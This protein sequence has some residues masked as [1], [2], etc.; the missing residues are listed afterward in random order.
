MG[1]GGATQAPDTQQYCGHLAGGGG[2]FLP[3]FML[4]RLPKGFPQSGLSR[5]YMGPAS[6][7]AG[8]EAK[9]AR[10][11][12]FGDLPGLCANTPKRTGVASTKESAGLEPQGLGR[13]DL[14]RHLP[15]ESVLGPMQCA[16]T[17]ID[18]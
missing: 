9:G 7:Y 15:S 14:W 4:K 8:A 2:I 5:N 13:V 18:S 3:L 10:R 17:R 16:A 6:S 1:T 11:P 12:V